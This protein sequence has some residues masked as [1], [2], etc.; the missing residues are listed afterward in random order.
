MFAPAV[1]DSRH[2]GG[3]AVA[4][5]PPS[6]P[7]SLLTSKAIIVATRQGKRGSDRPKAHLRQPLIDTKR[8]LPKAAQQAMQIQPLIQ[9]ARTQI[10][11]SPVPRSAA[12]YPVP[13][14][15]LL[16][17][18]ALKE[19]TAQATGQTTGQAMD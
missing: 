2:K 11:S 1:R 17:C 19:R 6:L 14:W 18:R 8:P 5:I 15:A 10:V 13:Q 16:T 9:T 3:L 4:Q 7:P 12:A